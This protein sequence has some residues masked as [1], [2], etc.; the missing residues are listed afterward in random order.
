M[1]LAKSH[2]QS[3][4]PNPR[5]LVL[6]TIEQSENHFLLSVYVEQVPCCPECGRLSHSRHSS[7]VRRLQDFPWQG[8]AVHILLRVR[9][10]RCRNRRCPRRVFTE[11]I[12]GI[13]S[14]LRQTSRL[15]E[16]VRVVGYAAGGLPGARL[17]ARLAI[18]TS[19]DTVLRRVKAPASP[20][21][22]APDGGSRCG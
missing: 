9:R 17:L 22:S 20:D 19:D 8:L 1:A 2:S 13:P 15:A 4:L 14:Y 11:R 7:Y 3:V 6:E 21:P 18:R 16:I 12:A 10:F 5:S